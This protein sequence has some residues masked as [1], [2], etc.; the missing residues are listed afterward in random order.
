MLRNGEFLEH[1]LLSD[2]FWFG[3]ERREEKQNL[4][5]MLNRQK[6]TTQVT[7]NQ[8]GQVEIE[9]RRTHKERRHHSWNNFVKHQTQW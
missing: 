9:Q 4:G 2:K 8:S 6:K 7:S 1:F 3:E 5:E